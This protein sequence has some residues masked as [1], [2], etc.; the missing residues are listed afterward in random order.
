MRKP[1]Q[2]YNKLA[3]LLHWLSAIVIVCLFVLGLWMLDLN[4]Y[5][6]WYYTAPHIH[7]SVGLCLFILTLLRILWKISTAAPAIDGKDWEI[8]AAKLTHALLY[9]LLIGILISGYMITTADGSGIAVF[10]WF[11]VPG[12]GSIVENQEDIAGTIHYYL[13]LILIGLAIVHALA[14]LKHHFINKDNT[15]SKMI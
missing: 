1:V 8:Q 6:D 9:I 11:S 5:H 15:L 12:F 3:K 7:K 14:A 10:N 2:Q 13:A 4:Y